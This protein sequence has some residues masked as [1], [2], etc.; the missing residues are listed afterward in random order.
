[1]KRNILVFGSISG[2]I[3]A[4]FMAISM[5]M[6]AG[7]GEHS[8]GNGGMIIGF[9]SM[10]VA[11]SLVFVG[12]KNYRDKQ[13]GGTLTFGK[14]FLLGFMIS[15]LASTIYVINGQKLILIFST[16]LTLIAIIFN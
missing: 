15:L 1:M 14:G 10:V 13:N 9:A 4:T 12:I 6:M 5:A 3:V 11:F 8:S 7:T 16:T 2:V